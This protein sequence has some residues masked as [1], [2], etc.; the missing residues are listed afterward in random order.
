[1]YTLITIFYVSLVGMTLLVVLKRREAISGHPSIVSRFGSGTDHIFQAVFSRVGR[2]ISYVNKHTFIA[3][4]HLIAFHVLKFVR[5]FYVELKHRFI[6]NP[7]GK[8]LIDAVRGRGELRADGA[9]FY[10]RR[11]AARDK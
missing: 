8:K 9:S 5:G 7:Q 2:A 6:S 3:M 11:I 1:M 4:G 10:L